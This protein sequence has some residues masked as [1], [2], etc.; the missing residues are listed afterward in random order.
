MFYRIQ[1]PSYAP[2]AL[3]LPENQTSLS[4]ST[5][6]I[7]NGV[8]VCRSIE[9]LAAYFCQAGVPMDP[10]TSILVELDGDYSEDEGEDAELGEY[11]VY[12]THIISA[13]PIPD[14]FFEAVDAF[15]DAA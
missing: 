10:H 12:P 6:T 5:D 2:E 11:L 7:R 13:G 14:E 9:E 1:S 8:S 15:Y 4:Y 3:L